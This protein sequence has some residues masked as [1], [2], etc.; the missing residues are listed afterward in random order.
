MLLRIP[1][2]GGNWNNGANAGLFKLNLNNARSNANSN[3]GFRAA[4][5]GTSV[6]YV[7]RDI[8]QYARIRASIPLAE[9]IESK[10]TKGPLQLVARGQY[11]YEQTCRR[12]VQR[13][14]EM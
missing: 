12:N 7:L 10:N 3:I 9:I 8:F 4:S 5:P 11:S 14:Y 13:M 1:I 6:V 2:A